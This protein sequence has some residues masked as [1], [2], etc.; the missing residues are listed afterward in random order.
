MA[1]DLVAVAV[2]DGDYG[3]AV[4]QSLYFIA[5]SS[6]LVNAVWIATKGRSEVPGKDSR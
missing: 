1:V 2:K 5:L 4:A 3:L 6:G